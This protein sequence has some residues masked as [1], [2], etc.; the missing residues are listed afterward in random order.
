M[1]FSASEDTAVD[2]NWASPFAANP[3]KRSLF[4]RLSHA[5]SEP[6]LN[7]LKSLAPFAQKVLAFTY[8]QVKNSVGCPGK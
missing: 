3:E 2:T 4:D 5:S 8:Y 1:K 7:H 6:G